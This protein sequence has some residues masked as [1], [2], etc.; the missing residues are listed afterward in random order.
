MLH[1]TL[2]LFG[3]PGC[4]CHSITSLPFTMGNA[5][6]GI[7]RQKGHEVSRWPTTR[8]SLSHSLDDSTKA[9]QVQGRVDHLVAYRKAGMSSQPTLRGRP[10]VVPYS[11]PMRRRSSARSPKTSVGY[12]PAPTRVV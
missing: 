3:D 9:A 12:G 11:T 6:N 1:A 10:V 4:G 2:F 5:R 8:P 7:T